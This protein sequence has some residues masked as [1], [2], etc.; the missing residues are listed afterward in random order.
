MQAVSTC[1]EL[2]LDEG[3]F[4]KFA[5][6]VN[7]AAVS[8]ADLVLISGTYIGLKHHGRIRGLNQLFGGILSATQG[9]AGQFRAEYPGAGLV[10]LH[11]SNKVLHAIPMLPPHFFRSVSTATIAS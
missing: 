9:R 2:L 4:D 7:P 1:S 10:F 5:P 6:L 3:A 11:G 8:G